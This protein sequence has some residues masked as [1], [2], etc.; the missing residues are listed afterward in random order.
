MEK[1]INKNTV[2]SILQQGLDRKFNRRTLLTRSS[3]LAFGLSTMGLL[4]ACEAEDAGDGEEEPGASVDDDTTDDVA[5]D[6]EAG[7]EPDEEVEP[8]ESE[9]DEATGEPEPSGGTV[10]VALGVALR[11]LDPSTIHGDGHDYLQH[12][13]HDTL[14]HFDEE[15]ELVPRLA[16]S[17]DIVDE[18]TYVINLREGVL[19]HDGTELN[20]SDVKFSFERC[21]MYPE[22]ALEFSTCWFAPIMGEGVVEVVDDNTVQFNLPQPDGTFLAQTVRE[23][24]VPEDAVREM[25]P[26][27]FNEHG[28]GTGAYK[29]KEWVRDQYVHVERFED[30]WGTSPVP[31]EL[32]IRAIPEASTRVSAVRAGEVDIVVNVPPDSIELVEEDEN[33]RIEAADSG[34]LIFVHLNTWEPPTDDVRVRRAMNHAVNWDEIIEHVLGGMGTRTPAPITRFT[35]PYEH[36]EDIIEEKAMHYDPDLAREL[37][38]EA[39]YGDGF[40]L[41]LEGPDGRY[42]LDSEVVQ[43]VGQYLEEVGIA[44][45]INIQEWGAYTSRRRE[46]EVQAGLFGMANA[47]NDFD[48]PLGIYWDPDR[49]DPYFQ[50]ERLKEL[51]DN[52][53]ATPFE[54]ERIEIYREAMEIVM[55]NAPWI[56]G[57][58]QAAIFGVTNRIEWTPREGTE[59][60]SMFDVTAIND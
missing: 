9:D 41:E 39:G 10:V 33:A 8:D 13:T 38:E 27:E 57:Y 29:V 16:E 50:D 25:G 40:E 12:H 37:L 54:E 32:I 11:F 22:T 44:V 31:E 56:F 18:T 35:F 55:D 48:T 23:Q 20:A 52:A 15:M 30:Y 51:L 34:R 5:D 24:I 46:L 1:K 36:L 17:V 21:V 3:I 7:D 42:L 47:I 53:L 60:V 59:L 26:E 58:S 6:T 28:I 4:A 49:T 45:D 2:S 19:F 43:A 14:M